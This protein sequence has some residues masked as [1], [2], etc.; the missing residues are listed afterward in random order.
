MTVSKRRRT[1]YQ[2]EPNSGT[3]NRSILMS[4]DK[5]FAPAPEETRL[6][7]VE[8]LAVGG[9]LHLAIQG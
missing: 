8:Y 6:L 1:L 4:K 2:T 9:F 3:I 7:C 5:L